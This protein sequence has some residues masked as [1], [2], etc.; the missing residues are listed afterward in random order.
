[1]LNFEMIS[2]FPLFRYLATSI[3][4]KLP[5]PGCQ[6]VFDHDRLDMI[7]SWKLRETLEHDLCTG[8]MPALITILFRSSGRSIQAPVYL[9]AVTH[10][11]C[12]IFSLDNG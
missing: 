7:P 10:D 9:I 1:M 3:P 2:L 11:K 8:F 6:C 5:V 4:H 12:E